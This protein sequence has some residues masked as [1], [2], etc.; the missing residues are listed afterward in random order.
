VCA[1]TGGPRFHRGA[2]GFSH[3]TIARRNQSEISRDTNGLGKGD[4]IQRDTPSVKMVTSREP[5]RSWPD[6]VNKAWP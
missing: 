1:S 4:N 2:I 6:E 5:N 3:N